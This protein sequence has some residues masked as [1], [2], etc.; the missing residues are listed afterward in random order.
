MRSKILLVLACLSLCF[1]AAGSA[2]TAEKFLLVASTI[3]PV[4]AGIVPLL[5]DRFQEETGIV[6]RHVGAGTGEAL[7]MAESGTFD[8][9]LVHAKSL[10]EA[11]VNKGFGTRRIPLMYND[12]VIVGPSADPAGI[13]GMKS[14]TD[15]LKAISA[16]GATFVSRG[17]KSGTHVA[18]QEL[19]NKSG[20]KPAAPW[21][22]V[23]EKGKDGNGPTLKYTDTIAAYT[24]MDRATYLSLKDS[25]K[26]TVLVEKDEA[27][28]NYMSVIPVNQQ[29]FP[30][31]NEKDAAAFVEWLT[32]PDKGQRIIA[33]FGRGK[34]GQPL[35]YPNSVQW[36]AKR[37][38]K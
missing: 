1:P 13:K 10:E 31:V 2:E 18:E 25:I 33:E 9:V 16:A 36:Q 22:Q 37:V 19:W 26:L 38:K 4:D 17:D 29:K 20:I 11:F 30:S 14:A 23:Y 15:A 21:Y 24:F 8:L 7:K 6:V 35:F 5:E 27:L 32:D 34:Y 3:G 12:F 28:L